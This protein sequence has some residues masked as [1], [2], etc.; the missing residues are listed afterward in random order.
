MLDSMSQSDMNSAKTSLKDFEDFLPSN[1]GPSRPRPQTV[2]DL[3]DITC[4]IQH[5]PKSGSTAAV[6][7]SLD[8]SESEGKAPAASQSSGGKRG[9]TSIA[10]LLGPGSSAPSK[11]TKL[12]YGALV[13]D[14]VKYRKKEALGMV[15]NGRTLAD[16][17]S[18]KRA[19]T[20]FQA[21]TN[22]PPRSRLLG[23][24]ADRAQSMV[25]AEESWS[26]LVCT[27]SVASAYAY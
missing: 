1:A 4:D 6:S 13:K 14:E 26:C 2:E 5:L 7:N 22:D 24:M 23:I 16:Q 10:D 19:D 9:Q 20:S 12:S 17:P 21:T 27:L 18:A 25:L 3:T 15:G 11:K 8:K